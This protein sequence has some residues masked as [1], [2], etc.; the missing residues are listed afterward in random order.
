MHLIRGGGPIFGSEYSKCYFLFK[1][2]IL[3]EV[4]KFYIKRAKNYG[5]D[6]TVDAETYNR[7]FDVVTAGNALT[8]G[9]G[10]D[11]R[12]VLG[13]L[14]ETGYQPVIYNANFGTDIIPDLDVK[15]AKTLQ[16]GITNRM[17]PAFM[18]LSKK[19]FIGSGLGEAHYNNPWH[20]YYE[21][22]SPVVMKEFS[23]LLSS[24]GIEMEFISP[25]AVLPYNIIQ[26]ILFQR[27][28]ELYK[29]QYSVKPG[30]ESEKN[31]HVSLCKIYHGIDFSQHCSDELFRRLLKKFT[32]DGIAQPEDY[33]FRGNREII[34]KE[35]RSIIYKMRDHELFSEVKD[36]VPQSWDGEWIDCI[37]TYIYPDIDSKIMEIF[38]EYSPRIEDCL[39]HGE[40]YLPGHQEQ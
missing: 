10:K 6:L 5:L 12:L 22:A 32:E 23:T 15:R 11:S 26:K 30:D 25:A 4:K 29:Y 24:L 27:Y 35:M 34:R 17:M 2:P 20:E 33:A 37:H 7:T 8:F 39:P 16:Y 9:G 14:N 19:V 36:I 40:G 28:P 38:T 13:L 3:E 18:S 31:L 1:Y 21:W